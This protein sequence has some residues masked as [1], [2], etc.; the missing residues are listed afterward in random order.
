M[1]VVVAQANLDGAGVLRGDLT[2]E[3]AAMVQ[4]ALDAP[5]AP[6]GS[7]DLGTWPQR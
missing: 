7:G 5:S 1:F 4:A 3:R 2:P 6:T